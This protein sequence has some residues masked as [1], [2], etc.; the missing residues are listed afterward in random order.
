MDDL[1]VKDVLTFLALVTVVT[2]VLLIPL[3]FASKSNEQ[4]FFNR[5]S[6]DYS[7]GIP[8]NANPYTHNRDRTEWLDGWIEAKNE[9]R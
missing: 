8:A 3:Y 6:S 1:F 9:E 4:Q 7:E 2:F 5:G